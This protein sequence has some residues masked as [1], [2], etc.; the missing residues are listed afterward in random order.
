MAFVRYEGSG[1]VLSQ[2]LFYG[3]ELRFSNAQLNN[4]DENLY[5][6]ITNQVL[7]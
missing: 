5:I 1:I 2:L 3:L 4:R 7:R 6:E